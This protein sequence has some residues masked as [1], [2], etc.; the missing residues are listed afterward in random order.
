[1]CI[2]SAFMYLWGIWHKSGSR[3]EEFTM[4]SIKGA[5]KGRAIAYM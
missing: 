1:M 5:E 4:K 3:A 2:F